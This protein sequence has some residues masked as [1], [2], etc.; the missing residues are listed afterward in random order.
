MPGAPHVVYDKVGDGGGFGGS[1]DPHWVGGSKIESN[2]VMVIYGD[3]MVIYGDLWWFNGDLWWF[4]GDLWGFNRGYNG[5][6]PL[7]ICYSPPW[8][9]MAHS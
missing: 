3:L 8:K 2:L 1:Q 9:M 6:Y 7:V 4:N 5:I